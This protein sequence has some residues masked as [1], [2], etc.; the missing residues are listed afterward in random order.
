M[1]TNDVTL[2][3]LTNPYYQNVITARNKNIINEDE[4]GNNITKEKAD[5]W[6]KG[7]LEEK[8][9]DYFYP[10]RSQLIGR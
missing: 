8:I 2:K 1:E 3:Y 5:T 9:Y 7:R 10:I 6:F 4:P